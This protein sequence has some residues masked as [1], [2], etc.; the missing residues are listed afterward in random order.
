MLTCRTLLCDHCCV[1]HYV[2]TSY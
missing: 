1:Y 2:F